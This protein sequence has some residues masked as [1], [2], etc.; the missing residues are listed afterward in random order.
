MTTSSENLLS[1][2][3]AARQAG[4]SRQRLQQLAVAGKLAGAKRV[5]CYWVVPASSLPVR[6]R[7]GKRR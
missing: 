6:Q 7:P 5:G 3:E 4:L 1:L 2:K